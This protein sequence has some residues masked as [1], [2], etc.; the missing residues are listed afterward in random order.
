MHTTNIN[1]QHYRESPNIT[2]NL[3]SFLAPGPVRNVTVELR[4]SSTAVLYWKQPDKPNGI[5]THYQVFYTGYNG[6]QVHCIANTVVC[7]AVGLLVPTFQSE[8]FSDSY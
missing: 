8:V 1:I 4:D 6:T 3:L 7:M 2:Y 5:I